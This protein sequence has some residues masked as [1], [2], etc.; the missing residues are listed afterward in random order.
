MSM[1]ISPELMGN[2][3]A[4]LINFGAAFGA[5]LGLVMCRR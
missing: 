5:M 1:E 4:M 3:M 2:A